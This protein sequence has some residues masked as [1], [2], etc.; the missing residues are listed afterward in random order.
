MDLRTW[1]EDK[2]RRNYDRVFLLFEGK[3]YTYG[4]F[5]RNVNRVANALGGLGIG[6]GDKIAIML[7]NIP[8]HLYT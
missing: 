1:M 4:E 2:V 5:D 7:P 8:E 3:E 6:R